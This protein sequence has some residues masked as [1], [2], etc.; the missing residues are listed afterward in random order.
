MPYYDPPNSDLTRLAFLK[1]ALATHAADE[2][3]GAAHLSAETLVALT[4]LAAQFESALGSVDQK[5]SA[6]TRETGERVEAMARVETC[7]RDLWEVLKRRVVRQN[8]HASVL[9]FY[10]LP[11]DGA[12][13]QP[14]TYEEWLTLAERAVS[15]DAA[16]VAAG[17]PA[18]VNPSAAELGGVVATARQE[19]ADVAPADLAYDEAQAAVA[20]LRPQVDAAITDV[21]AEL[22]FALRR[23]DPPSQRRVLRRYGARFRYLEGEPVEDE[24]G[25]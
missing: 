22:R 3:A 21:V 14:T 8:E 25:G 17:H 16:A 1:R 2:L 5:L 19:T 13:P 4:G 10:G 20:E 9:A 24:D 23:L 6:R 18:M 12:L 15:G 11:L 7:L